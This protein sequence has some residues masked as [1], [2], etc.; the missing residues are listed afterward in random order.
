[1]NKKLLALLTGIL[2]SAMIMAG[3]NADD[4]DPAPPN[5]TDLNEVEENIEEPFENPDGDAVDENDMNNGVDGDNGLN[6]AE[7]N[8]EEP[9]ENPDNDA[10]DENDPNPAD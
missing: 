3:C 2:L 6:N 9:F 7:E 1:M 8:L 10:V 5:D 4:P